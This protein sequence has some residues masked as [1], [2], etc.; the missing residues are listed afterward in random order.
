MCIITT[1]IHVFLL[2]SERYV[3]SDLLFLEYLY[4][5]N[6]QMFNYSFEGCVVRRIVS[7]INPCTDGAYVIA[8]SYEG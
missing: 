7:L 5:I 6:A 1:Y 8:R 3:G 2:M 4:F